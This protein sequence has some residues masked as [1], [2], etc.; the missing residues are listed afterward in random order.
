MSSEAPLLSHAR[1]PRD[2]ACVRWIGMQYAIRLD[3]LRRLLYRYTPDADRYK[4]RTDRD[5][6]SLDRTY[7][8]L[9]KWKEQGLIEQDPIL[10]RDPLWIW[11]TRAGLRE[12]GLSFSYS[13]APAS[14]RLPHL[15]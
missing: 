5:L 4:L 9:K 1:T 3:Q 11:L 2:E 14:A 6:L 12:V 13:G 7:K 10:Y 15:Y 8:T